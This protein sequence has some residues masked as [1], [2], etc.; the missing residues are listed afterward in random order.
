MI[1]RVFN[2]D[3]KRMIPVAMALVVMGLSMVT[4]GIN[5]PQ[6]SLP[7]V[8]AGTDWNDFFRGAMFGI[9]IALE[10]CGVALAAKAAALKRRASAG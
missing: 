4:I 3:P 2:D 1:L 10:I 6:S 8:H 7:P 9:A 5:W